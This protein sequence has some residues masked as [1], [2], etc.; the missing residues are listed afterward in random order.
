M[1][2]VLRVPLAMNGT[3]KGIYSED[4]IRAAW[5][6]ALV[7]A[8]LGTLVEIEEVSIERTPAMNGRISAFQ[9]T[10]FVTFDPQ[11]EK[12]RS[13]FLEAVQHMYLSLQPYSGIS[14]GIGERHIHIAP[15]SG[16]TDDWL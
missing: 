12:T 6:A 8:V 16:P 13:A 3:Y 2:N 4:S 10:T 9:L 15:V 11:D 1:A 14:L 5:E 7:S